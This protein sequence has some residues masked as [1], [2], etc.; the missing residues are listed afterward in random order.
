MLRLSPHVH[1]D[2]H[3]GLGPGHMTDTTGDGFTTDPSRGTTK[4]AGEGPLH[5]IIPAIANAIH[6]AVGIRLRRIPFTP[7]RVL[8]ALEDSRC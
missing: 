4:E 2:H 7:E 3:H 5:P 8:Q 1:D 6:D